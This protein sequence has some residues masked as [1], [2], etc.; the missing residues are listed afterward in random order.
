MHMGPKR[1]TQLPTCQKRGDEEETVWG[2]YSKDRRR[3]DPLQLEIDEPADQKKPKP[4]IM[5]DNAMNDLWPKSQVMGL[6]WRLKRRI[7][8]RSMFPPHHGL[9]LPTIS[10]EQI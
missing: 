5:L 10:L 3:L 6:A 4:L 1:D 8:P 7:N 9:K 2:A